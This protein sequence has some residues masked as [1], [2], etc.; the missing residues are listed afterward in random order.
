MQHI[1]NVAFDF[2]D[3]RVKKILEETTVDKIQ[4]EI[5]QAILDEIFEKQWGNKHAVP[6]RD[7]FREWV[8]QYIKDLIAEY[9]DDI[10][11]HT[12]KE[13]VEKFSKS[14]SFREK[15]AVQMLKEKHE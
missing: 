10:C 14:N 3:E 5:K 9:K 8:R 4:K 1:V 7:P 2:D 15:V 12:A 13:L 6:D 11:K